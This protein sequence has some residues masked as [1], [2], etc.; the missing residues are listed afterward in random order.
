MVNVHII[1]N[2]LNKL[3]KQGKGAIYVVIYANINGNQKRKFINTGI[4]IEPVYWE[5]KHY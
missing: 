4:K 3:D 1:F 2:K 5:K